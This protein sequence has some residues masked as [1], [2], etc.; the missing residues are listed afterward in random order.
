M[1]KYVIP[2]PVNEINCRDCWDL[3][4]RAKLKEG[5]AF[6]IR[7]EMHAWSRTHVLSLNHP[8]YN[9]ISENHQDSSQDVRFFA[10]SERTQCNSCSWTSIKLNARQ[11]LIYG[12]YFNKQLLGT[13][14]SFASLQRHVW[15]YSNPVLEILWKNGEYETWI[16]LRPLYIDPGYHCPYVTD[17]GRT[18]LFFFT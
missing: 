3:S 7:D 12:C 5:V 2:S 14:C 1:S 13:L 4:S 11:T 8:L 10:L 9:R 18:P 6:N 16:R 17:K 15:E